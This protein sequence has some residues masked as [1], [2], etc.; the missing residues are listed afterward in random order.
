MNPHAATRD[1][2]V[3][4]RAHSP[5]CQ[6]SKNPPQPPTRGT[7]RPSTSRSGLFITGSF[8]CRCI[9]P[10]VEIHGAHRVRTCIISLRRRKLY[11]FK[12]T[13][14]LRRLQAQHH[15]K[16]KTFCLF[17]QSKQARRIELQRQAQHVFI[18]LATI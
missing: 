18:V 1:H 13:L 2:S 8:Q 16:R 6:L 14:H 17:L 3:S 10:W 15:Y 12:L 5:F 11:P 7:R 9:L 4:N